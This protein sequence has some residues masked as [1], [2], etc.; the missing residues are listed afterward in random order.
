MKKDKKLKKYIFE[1]KMGV[2]T[3][4]SLVL[5]IVPVIITGFLFN[6]EIELSFSDS[7]SFFMDGVT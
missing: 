7:S 6:F 4:L 2:I 1:Y 3:I 5:F